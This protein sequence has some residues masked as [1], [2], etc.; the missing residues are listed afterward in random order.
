MQDSIFIKKLYLMNS[1]L[2]YWNHMRYPTFTLFHG[3]THNHFPWL[4]ESYRITV[5]L[6]LAERSVYVKLIHS[7]ASKWKDK[8]ICCLSCHL[9]MKAR[10]IKPVVFFFFFKIFLQLFHFQLSNEGSS[11]QHT[12]ASLHWG[13]EASLILSFNLY[14]CKMVT[15]S[16]LIKL[17]LHTKVVVWE[18]SWSGSYLTEFLTSTSFQRNYYLEPK[19]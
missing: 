2:K 7:F 19:K 17:L 12:E 13:Y 4:D 6:Y 8:S 10:K 15:Y 5:K 14:T 1:G 16:N 3:I 18:T 11:V 9:F